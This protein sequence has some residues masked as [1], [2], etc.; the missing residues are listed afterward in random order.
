MGHVAGSR[1]TG[2][3]SLVLYLPRAGCPASSGPTARLFCALV[4]YESSPSPG[5]QSVPDTLWG[6]PAS[7]ARRG[8]CN[9]GPSALGQA[10][11]MI[12]P[13]AH[14]HAHLP[15]VSQGQSPQTGQA[16]TGPCLGRHLVVA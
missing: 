11:A 16:D 14:L 7:P 3:L 4:T 1:E 13:F 15:G 8:S 6:L 2:L 9:A 12:P 5:P 10:S